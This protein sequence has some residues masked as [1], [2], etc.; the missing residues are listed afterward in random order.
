MKRLLD[1]L[2]LLAAAPLLAPLTAVLAALVL[3]VDGRP[4]FFR[5]RRLGRGRVP[6]D[7]WKLRTMT[8]EVDPAAR[9]V[10][11]LGRALREH[12][13]DELP[14]LWN[15]LRGE[16]SLVGPRPLTPADADRLVEKHPFFAARFASAP[17]LTGLAQICMARSAPAT[18]ELD[19]FYARR[20]SLR[21]DLWILGRT[22]GMNILGKRRGALGPRGG[23]LH[24]RMLD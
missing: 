17:G 8:A 19:A 21:M 20:R 11:D 9:R 13:L 23:V 4:V 24:Y 15:V 3:I 16:M 5:Q 1:T 7:I 22:A 2:L 18:A 12:G 6:F 10:T 14:Q